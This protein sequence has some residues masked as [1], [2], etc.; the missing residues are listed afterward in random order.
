VIDAARSAQQLAAQCLDRAAVRVVEMSNVVAR[1][2]VELP[3]D[4]SV[5]G[6]FEAGAKLQ[7]RGTI[8]GPHCAYAHTLTAAVSLREVTVRPPVGNPAIL[9]REAALPDPCFWTP[10]LPHRYRLKL[11]LAHGNEVLAEADRWLGLRPLDVR[12][13]GFWFDGA[14]WVLRAANRELVP[15]ANLTQWRDASL[16]MIVRSPQDALCE[17]ASKVGVLLIAEIGGFAPQVVAQLQRLSRHA[18]VGMAIVASTDP[19]DIDVRRVAGGIMLIQRLVA[20]SGLDATAGL[21][22]SASPQASSFTPHASPT[23][24]TGSASASTLS[25]PQ[26]WPQALLV[27]GS[28]P[29]FVEH[30]AGKFSLPVIVETAV[31]SCPTLAAARRACDTL[32]ADTAGR[33]HIAGYLIRAA[34]DSSKR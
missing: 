31:A 4:N 19:L 8:D 34:V 14:G 9:L 1:V 30:V 24:A 13:Q 3:V 6:L 20:T 16:A 33:S 27:V 26:P 22:S 7:L 17:E 11:Q 29:T 5:A 23:G 2:R 28:E 10:Q 21:S 25:E 18:A 12:G 32:Q 15:G